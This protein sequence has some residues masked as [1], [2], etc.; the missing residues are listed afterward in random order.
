MST[1]TF[2]RVVLQCDGCLRRH[3]D[4]HGHNSAQEARAA[5]YGDGWRF[6]A[7]VRAD[8]TPGNGSSDVCGSCIPAWRP[9]RWGERPASSVRL[10]VDAAPREEATP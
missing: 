3:G 8:G 1:L 5:A 7:T 10:P 4:P 9:K 2:S 6:P